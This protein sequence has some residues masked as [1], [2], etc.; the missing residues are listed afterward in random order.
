M[1]GNTRL[2]NIQALRAIAAVMVMLLHTAG[3]A[4]NLGFNS[5]AQ[6]FQYIGFAGVDIFFVISGLVMTLTTY[7][8][9]GEK[10]YTLRFIQRRATRIYSNYWVILLIKFTCIYLGWMTLNSNVEIFDSITL[11]TQDQSH[12]VIAIAWT[13]VF[14]LFFYVIFSFAIFLPK[15]YFIHFISIWAAII[16]FANIFFIEHSNQMPFAHY[17]Y[18]SPLHLEFIS[19]CFIG[20]LV[21]KGVVILPR[22]IFILGIILM[23]VVAYV[24]REAPLVGIRD[25]FMRAVCYGG[26]ASLMLYGATTMEKTGAFT[27]PGWASRF[28]DASYTIYLVHGIFLQ[29]ALTLIYRP[30]LDGSENALLQ[31]GYILFIVMLVLAY[32]RV[33]YR[34]IE[35]PLLNWCNA[36]FQLP[37]KQQSQ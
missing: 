27:F 19:G 17:F 1:T 24:T 7:K 30:F 35:K 18:L 36:K 15:N 8:H 14:E 34:Y 13:L 9:L 11:L 37:K 5:W 21:I 2:N 4:N 16:L 33:H 29:S 6:P 31:Q 26:S 25:F 28:G 32:S 20:L 12:L 23:I 3:V 10:I 22:L